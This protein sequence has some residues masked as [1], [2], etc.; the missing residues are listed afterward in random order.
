M[1]SGRV[2]LQAGLKGHMS[3]KP[4]ARRLRATPGA[5]GARFLG[6]QAES[7]MTGA[8]AQGWA[9]WGDAVF[10]L[11]G[12]CLVVLALAACD[13]EK[14]A[15]KE[16]LDFAK[17][18]IGLFQARDFDAIE[19]GLDPKLKTGA[20]LTSLQ[21]LA[22]YFPA[23]AP[24]KVELIHFDFISSASGTTESFQFLYHFPKQPLQV[25]ISFEKH[26]QSRLVSDIQVAP[27]TPGSDFSLSNLTPIKIVFLVLAMAIPLFILVMLGLCISTPM[28]KGKWLWAIFILIGLIGI[29][30][31]WTSSEITIQPLSVLL[32]GA[33]MDSGERASLS[34]SLPLGAIL[35]LIYRRRWRRQAAQDRAST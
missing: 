6:A 18:Y 23:E 34:I 32:F 22:D 33:A 12:F 35:F 15:P 9:G 21:S 27:A 28:L 5:A 29:T 20:L 4:G 1:K 13:L 24:T 8:P 17:H 7:K 2:V 14:F 30:L 10:R 31:D 11:L 19:A 3:V 16:E 25:A 26:D